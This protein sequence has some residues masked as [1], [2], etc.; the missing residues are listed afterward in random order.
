MKISVI[1]IDDKVPGS[2]CNGNNNNNCLLP[3]FIIQ[4]DAKF[5]LEVNE[6]KAFVCF[7]IQIQGHH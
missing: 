1:S 4:G 7:A 3:I 2:I 6:N 5:H